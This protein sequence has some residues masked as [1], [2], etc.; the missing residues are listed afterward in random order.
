MNAVIWNQK[1]VNNIKAFKSIGL[2]FETIAN[3]YDVKSFQIKR[4]YIEAIRQEQKNKKEKEF[5]DI[6]KDFYL[7]DKEFKSLMLEY[8]TDK[9]IKTSVKIDDNFIS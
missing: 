6:L 4:L 7:Q 9:L 3:N 8:I 5:K 1:E 2:D